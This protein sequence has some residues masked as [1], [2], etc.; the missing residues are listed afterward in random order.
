MKNVKLD[1]NL[2]DKQTLF[3]YI[4]H[5]VVYFKDLVVRFSHH[6]NSIE[7]NTLSIA[8]TTALLYNT[9]NVM[10]HAKPREI[11]EAINQKVAI[12]YIIDN[13]KKPLEEKDIKNIATIINNNIGNHKDYRTVSVIIKGA[14]HIPPVPEKISQLMMYF[15]YNY[16]NTDYDDIFRKVATT[17]IDF[18]RIH[19]FED[20]NG[21]TGRLIMLY[22]F[23]KNN[24][25][26]A[27]I[28][29]ANKL[30]YFNY[31]ANQDITGLAGLLKTLSDKESERIAYFKTL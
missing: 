2:G 13:I 15:L 12:E 10:L 24:T 11:N 21:R 14:E 9:E 7:G 1:L 19:P 22:E 29:S 27:I 26:P 4:I 28:T 5:D 6:S 20:G 16:N 30:E 18:E 17:H 3:D 8:E 23:L 25:A 31:I